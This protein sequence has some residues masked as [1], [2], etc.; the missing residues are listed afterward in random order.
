MS[1][2]KQKFKITKRSISK[3]LATFAYNYFLMKRQV[4]KTLFERKFISPFTTE[5]GVWN[6][7]QVPETY[8]H[9]ADIVSETLLLHKNL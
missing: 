2:K 9:Y 4:A 3:E 8:S 1:F 6:D 7:D 5:W